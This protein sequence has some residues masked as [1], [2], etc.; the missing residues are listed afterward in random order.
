MLETADDDVGP[1]LQ[2]AKRAPDELTEVG[3]VAWQRVFHDAF[4]PG[5]TGLLGIEV[6]GI[7]RQVGHREVARM[8]HQEGSRAVG[9]MSIQPVPDDQEGLADLASEMPQGPD[10]HLARDAASDMPGV[11]PPRRGHRDHAGHLASLA[12]PPQHRGRTAPRPSRPWTG[13]EAVSGFI[14]EDD[15]APLAAG[16][17]F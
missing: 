7:G 2:T 13:S 14:Q 9:A 1:V 15:G 4:D 11:Q 6:R 8:S 10:H 16:P 5:I 3:N 17:L 12:Q